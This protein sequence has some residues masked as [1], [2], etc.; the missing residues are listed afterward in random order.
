MSV[1]S[2]LSFISFHLIQFPQDIYDCHHPCILDRS[3]VG[4]YGAPSYGVVIGGSGLEDVGISNGSHVTSLLAM[5]RSKRLSNRSHCSGLIS[6]MKEVLSRRILKIINPCSRSF[7]V[8][9]VTS[10]YGSLR[11]HSARIAACP[12]L[13]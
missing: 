1:I 13:M 10:C 5:K 8:F 6:S 2:L 7:D 4:L 9:Q 3:A 11:H 12:C